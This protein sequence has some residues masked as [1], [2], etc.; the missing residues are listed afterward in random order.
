MCEAEHSGNDVDASNPVLEQN[1]PRVVIDFTVGPAG[2]GPPASIIPAAMGD[3]QA[4]PPPA[5]HSR[6]SRVV[7][8][9]CPPDGGA[10]AS[11]Q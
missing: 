11:D 9:A 5:E 3:A 2:V 10:V 8:S 1:Q 7:V 6:S 4:E